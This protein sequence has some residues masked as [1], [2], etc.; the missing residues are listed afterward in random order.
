[1]RRQ[2]T[3]V[4]LKMRTWHGCAYWRFDSNHPARPVEAGTAKFPDGLRQS[5][6]VV[7]GQACQR[8]HGAWLQ[9]EPL[10]PIGIS[11][12]ES[13]KRRTRVLCPPTVT[14]AVT[15]AHMAITPMRDSLYTRG[16]RAPGELHPAGYQV[17]SAR[18]PSK[19]AESGSDW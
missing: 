8:V 16:V 19:S 2:A 4:D 7:D 10:W 12:F 18:T 13:W 1:V 9:E 15:A 11:E 5:P 6:G 3:A 17:P 14:A